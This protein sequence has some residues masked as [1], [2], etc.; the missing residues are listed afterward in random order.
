[1]NP[2]RRPPHLPFLRS[3]A[4]GGLAALLL[5]PA[6][7]QGSGYYLFEADLRAGSVEGAQWE[8]GL[9]LSLYSD[10]LEALATIGDPDLGGGR[11][12]KE[13]WL[14]SRRL[15]PIM[16][17][18]PATMRAAGFA[19]EIR[20]GKQQLWIPFR[21]WSF[22]SDYTAGQWLE[23]DAS[24]HL[25]V[26]LAALTRINHSSLLFGP[27][28][29]AGVNLSWWEG[30]RGNDDQLI[31]TGKITAEAGWIAGICLADVGYTQARLLGWV[32]AFGI[33]QRQ[34]RF[35]GVLGVS[36]VEL[37]LPLGLELHWE[38][39]RGDDTVDTLPAASH[40]L[41]LAATWRLMPPR[42][43]ERKDA[44]MDA[45]RALPEAGGAERSVPLPSEDPA[46][47]Q[48]E[49]EPEGD[50]PNSQGENSET[51]EQKTEPGPSAPEP[52][53]EGELEQEP[54]R[55]PPGRRGPPL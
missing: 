28:L 46:R 34:L 4:L 52:S 9:G 45:L 20:L 23:W 25:L 37:G 42:G 3:P 13:W 21:S 47:T 33:H 26:N 49:E 14:A 54:E 6:A 19:E 50:P 39:E 40:S 48:A 44:L 16:G 43:E 35:V 12:V 53:E 1:M 2:T 17:N 5:A 32:D 27:T 30:W 11:R 31:A 10:E 8:G 24:H 55:D 38:F 41:M 22:G 15:G 18:L 29:G 51:E 36:G 7:A